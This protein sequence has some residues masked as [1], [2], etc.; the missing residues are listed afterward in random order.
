MMTPDSRSYG[1]A[2]GCL[3]RLVPRG[4]TVQEVRSR[5][6]GGEGLRVISTREPDHLPRRS[7]P[8]LFLFA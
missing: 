1:R 5:L 3:L 2:I 8:L 7:V 4:P 6:Q